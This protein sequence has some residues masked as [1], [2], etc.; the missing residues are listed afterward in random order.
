MP[1]ASSVGDQIEH[2]GDLLADHRA[3]D[4]PQLERIGDIVE[5]GHV[6]PDRVRLKDHAEIAPVRWHEEPARRRGDQT[7]AQRDLAGIRMLEPGHEAKGGGLAAAARPE[8]GEHLAP[9]DLERC[10]VHRRRHAVQLAHPVEREDRLAGGGR[11]LPHGAVGSYFINFITALAMSW[12]LTTSGKFS[13]AS[14]W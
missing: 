11:N 7:P 13:S 3:L 9:P 5:H 6:R 8:Q 14:T 10:A 2:P 4:S 12:V 1:T